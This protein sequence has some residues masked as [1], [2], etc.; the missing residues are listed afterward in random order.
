MK[1]YG[2]KTKYDLTS[3]DQHIHERY[4]TQPFK[5]GT[6]LELGAI[7]GIKLSNTKFFEDN[8][9][10][11]QGV[12]IEPVPNLY[13]KLVINRPHCE[14][15]NYA[16]HSE[17]KQVEFMTSSLH[18][19]GGCVKHEESERHI[20]LYHESGRFKDNSSTITI[21]AERLDNI[22]HRSKLEYIDFWSLDV[23][24]SELQCL[25]SMDWSIPVGLICVENHANTDDIHNILTGQGFK[26][27]EQTKLDGFYFNFDYPRKRYFNDCLQ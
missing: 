26:L 2:L 9:G 25:N 16:I 22:L 7:D 12:L 27:V 24:G 3:T 11:N 17:A 6:F 4:I 13:E 5:H 21:P 14:C 15:Y 23:E 18:D 20:E 19:W 1:Y 8:M 10:F